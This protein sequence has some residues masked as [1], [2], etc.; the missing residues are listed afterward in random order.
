MPNIINK[1]YATASETSQ[2]KN[3]IINPNGTIALSSIDYNDLLLSFDVSSIKSADSANIY[4]A[5]NEAKITAYSGFDSSKIKA[6]INLDS[7]VYSYE[8]CNYSS[9]TLNKGIEETGI[10]YIC[11]NDK[12]NIHLEPWVIGYSGNSTVSSAKDLCM[13]STEINISDS[14]IEIIS[15]EPSANNFNVNGNSIDN[16]IICNWENEDVL[17]WKLEA[18]QNDILIASKNGTSENTC[19]FVPGDINVA[20]KV[21]FKL[22]VYHGTSSNEYTKEVEL[23]GTQVKLFSIEPNLLPQKIYQPI[24]LTITGENMTNLDIKAVQNGTTKYSK[25]ISNNTL[26]TVSENILANTFSSGTVNIT[27][28]ATYNGPH[29]SNSVTQSVSFVAYGKPKAPTLN[30]QEEYATPSPLISWVLDVEQIQYQVIFN[31]EV[32]QDVYSSNIH[33]YQLEN[34]ENNKYYTV[35]VRIKNQYNEWSDYSSATFKVSFAEL[36]TPEVNVYSDRENSC[37]VIVATSPQQ[38]EFVKHEIYRRNTSENKWIKIKSN[39]PLELSFSDYSCGSGVLYE[40]KVRAVSNIGT[41]KDSS[42]CSSKV[43][44]TGRMISVPN[45][46]ICIELTNFDTIKDSLADILYNSNSSYLGICG[47]SVPKEVKSTQRY[48]TFSCK[49]CF[50][51]KEEYDK[52]LELENEE[53]LLYRDGKGETFYC[54]IQ[55]KST[56]DSAMYYKYISF[57]VTETYY[58]GVEYDKPAYFGYSKREW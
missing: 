29:Y 8:Y 58:S 11:N 19:T 9:G 21:I 26:S 48:K 7:S 13:L 45:T 53:I 5:I 41:F 35:K 47:L 1:I 25:V 28:T 43:D 12:V 23:S 55:I 18:I 44:F 14:Y 36:E 6:Y 4:I 51:T 24:E 10:N 17:S 57:T 37:I 50:E 40:Y 27:V 32:V 39:L 22:T 46:D 56:T 42:I 49:C 16:N 30:V 34:L 20:G 33:S 3:Y 54:T 38:D 15:I 2:T 31:D 52:F